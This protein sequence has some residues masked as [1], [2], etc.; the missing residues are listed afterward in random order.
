[1]TKPLLLIVF[2][3]QAW[4]AT[5]QEVTPT[6]FLARG[7]QAGKSEYAL[8]AL[9]A[10]NTVDARTQTEYTAGRAVILMPGFE[11]REGAVFTAHIGSATPMGETALLSVS[12]YPNP[13]V[14]AVTIGYVLAKPTRTRLYILD[15][16]GKVIRMLVDDVYQEAGA[17]QVEWKGGPVVAGMYTCLLEADRERVA[18]RMIRR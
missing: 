10:S 13:F 5:A 14:D 2:C 8:N 17:Y 16:Q 7:Y 4:T 9:I 1:M 15:T 12:A 3:F 18:R 6:R 11:V